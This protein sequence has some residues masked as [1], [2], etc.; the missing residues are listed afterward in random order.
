VVPNVV[1]KTLGQATRALTAHHCRLGPVARIVSSK[2]KNG[3]VLRES[4]AVGKHLRNNAKVSLWIGKGPR[5][6]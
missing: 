3:H 4:P 6:K 2:A 1:G 5:R